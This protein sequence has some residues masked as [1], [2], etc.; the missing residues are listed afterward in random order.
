MVFLFQCCGSGSGSARIRIKLKGRIWICIRT[1][2]ISWIR[3][4]IS[5]QMTS[6]NAWNISLFEHFFKV[7]LTLYLEARIRI[8]IRIRW[9][10]G[11]ESGSA[12]AS[13]WQAGPGSASKWQAGCRSATLLISMTWFVYFHDYSDPFLDAGIA[14]DKN[15]VFFYFSLLSVFV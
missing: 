10:V 6:L 2:V 8:R 13:K 12:S 4:R 1:N 15:V 14:A 3:I 5:L 7:L 11:S 9:K